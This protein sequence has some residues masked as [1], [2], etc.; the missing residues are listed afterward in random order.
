MAGEVRSVLR[1]A[2]AGVTGN[3]PAAIAASAFVCP[4]F[5]R[6]NVAYLPQI[7]KKRHRMSGNARVQRKSVTEIYTNLT[8][9]VSQNG[10]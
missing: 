3:G 5:T 7:V 2:A 6:G 8:Q 10:A 9:N 1:Y 4:R